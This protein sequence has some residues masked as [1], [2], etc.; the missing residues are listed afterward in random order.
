MSCSAL[1]SGKPGG[2]AHLP[3]VGRTCRA[4]HHPSLQVWGECLLLSLLHSFKNKAGVVQS[5]GNADSAA[6]SIHEIPMTFLLLNN[7]KIKRP[8]IGL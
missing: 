3:C 4:A 1:A 2:R 6:G 5:S 7:D 8:R